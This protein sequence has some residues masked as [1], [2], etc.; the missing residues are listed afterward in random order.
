MPR[1]ARRAGAEKSAYL[2]ESS[3][4]VS[5]RRVPRLHFHSGVE[6]SSGEADGGADT[7]RRPT[8]RQMLRRLSA[9]MPSW[10]TRI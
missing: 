3:A 5:K 8:A 7:G 4:S 9:A 2:S 1:P 10:T 6:R